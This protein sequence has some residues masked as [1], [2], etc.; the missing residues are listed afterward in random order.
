VALTTRAR[1][2][3]AKVSKVSTEGR[4]TWTVPAGT[5]GIRALY[6]IHDRGTDPT[7]ANTADYDA[8]DGGF[9]VTGVSLR[10]VVS[11]Q[12]T[13]YTGWTGSAVS[14]SAGTAMEIIGIFQKATVGDGAVVPRQRPRVATRVTFNENGEAVVNA[15]AAEDQAFIY[16]TVGDGSA[17]ADPTAAANDGIITG[18]SGTIDTGIKITTGNVAF[19]KAASAD[20][21]G[22]L[23]TVASSEEARRLGPFHKDT[24]TRTVTGVTV[25]TLAQAVTIPAGQLGLDGGMVLRG[26]VEVTSA[27]ANSKIVRVRLDTSATGVTGTLLGDF[28]VQDTSG[29]VHFEAVLFNEASASAQDSMVT[30]WCEGTNSAPVAL[31]RATAAI[32]TANASYLK[33]TCDPDVSGDFMDLVVSYAELI[34]TD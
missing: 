32:N 19:V 22:I 6:D 33:I 27:N 14:G 28:A 18:P 34:G 12:L 21:S 8:A 24:S 3:S 17:P 11:V 16:I 31:R 26:R 20:A 10:E 25:E 2:T 5:L 23:S 1:I 15:T 9:T 30:F 13:P 4:V 29:Q 7:F